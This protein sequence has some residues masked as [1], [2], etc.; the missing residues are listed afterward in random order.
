MEVYLG[1]VNEVGSHTGK[2]NW[3]TVEVDGV[4]ITHTEFLKQH[5]DI[6]ALDNATIVV[7][8]LTNGQSLREDISILLLAVA[9][10]L[11]THVLTVAD[12]ITP[13]QTTYQRVKRIGIVANG[14]KTA[15]Q[16][17]HRGSRHNINRDT[18]TLD[19]LQGADVGRSPGTTSTQ[20]N[21]NPLALLSEKRQDNHQGQQ[22]TGNLLHDNLTCSVSR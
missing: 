15:Y 7:V 19:N 14:I 4:R 13:I 9:Q 2:G 6:L 8:T 20:H 5:I 1:I 22:Q 12:D 11:T 16:T 21:G 10:A 3:Q 17:A 18:R